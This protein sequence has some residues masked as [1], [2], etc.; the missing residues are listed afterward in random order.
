MNEEIVIEAGTIEDFLKILT[1]NY[2]DFLC[3]RR[4]KTRQGDFFA[5]GDFLPLRGY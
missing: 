5:E 1:A 2:D 4:E 3:K